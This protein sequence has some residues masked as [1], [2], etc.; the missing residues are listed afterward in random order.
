MYDYERLPENVRG[1][2]ERYIEYG[3]TPGGFLTA[4]LEN[5]LADALGRADSNNLPRLQEILSWLHDE[6]P[7]VC[8]GSP[9]AVSAWQLEVRR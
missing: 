6:V 4:V 9:A 1:G 5:D 2:M 7:S 8:W 3:I